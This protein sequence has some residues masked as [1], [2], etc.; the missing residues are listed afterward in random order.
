MPLTEMAAFPV[1]AEM[2]SARKG[3]K[4]WRSIGVGEILE[5][6]KLSSRRI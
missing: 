3:R 6:V 4:V 5:F 1:A 2:A